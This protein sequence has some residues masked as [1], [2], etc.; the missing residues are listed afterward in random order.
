MILSFFASS[1]QRSFNSW[2]LEKDFFLTGFLAGF[3]ILFFFVL[4]LGSV[5]PC[6]KPILMVDIVILCQFIPE[7]LQ[8]LRSW[9]RPLFDWIFGRV[10]HIVFFCAL[11]G[12]C[13][14]LLK[15]NFNGWYCHS[16]PVHPRGASTVE[17][18]RK[19]SFWLDFWQ[20]FA[21][22]FF[23]FVLFLGSVKP[24]LKTNFNGWYCHSLPVHPRGA[25]TVEVLRKTSFWLDFWQGFAYCFFFF[26]L[27]LG[28]V[29]PCLK[30]ILLVDIVILCQ[31]IPEELQQ[32]RSWERPLFDWI[33][34]RVLHI[35]FFF[36]ALFGICQTMLKTN[37]NG[38]YCHSLPVHPRGA[39]TVEV[40]RKT[41]FWLDFW[42]GF[43]ILFFF[44][45][46]LGSV[47]PCLKPILM[48]DI[49]ILC[50]F[51]PEE[52]QQLR[53]WERPLFDWIFGR[54]LH[55]VF[56][57]VLFLGSVKPCLKPILM[58][59][60]VILCQFSPEELQQLR[61]WER[62]LFDWIFGRVLHIVFFCALFGIC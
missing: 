56:F 61:S 17:V 55:I 1:S 25:S 37:F 44:V 57:F 35:V 18:L 33:F 10:L 48:V 46:F 36:C 7:E 53:S 26:V 19:T 12:I 14:T 5:K 62:P 3:C 31:F 40:L 30:P 22:C 29:K 23:F 52:L 6:L 21:Y 16:L 43:A 8:Q 42:Q 13:Q 39:S 59:D 9:E 60:I 38:W 28:S 41:S 2:G 51:I 11:F 24:C 49:V 15:T 4:F 58:V 54:V 45:L 47:K 34:G 20:G 50:Q 32:L 27:F